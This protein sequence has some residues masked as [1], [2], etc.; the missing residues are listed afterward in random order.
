MLLYCWIG[1]EY[2]QNNVL[3]CNLQSGFSRSHLQF[4]YPGQFLLRL[5]KKKKVKNIHTNMAD[6]IFTLL[7]ILCF[8][9]KAACDSEIMFH[10]LGAR[11]M[12]IQHLMNNQVPLLTNNSQKSHSDSF[13]PHSIYLN[14]TVNHL[15]PSH[16]IKSQRSTPSLA[17]DR[18]SFC[19]AG[20]YRITLC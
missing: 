8:P 6:I 9:H 10:F 1:L 14:Y 2:I 13:G 18:G 11:Q 19:T 12:F 15:R 4:F 5:A 17:T 7:P 3:P 20:E 16:C